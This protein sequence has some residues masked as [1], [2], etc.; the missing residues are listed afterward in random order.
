MLKISQCEIK[1]FQ[2]FL[3]V[4]IFNPC[5]HSSNYPNAKNFNEKFDSS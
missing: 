5:E 2:Q 3:L 1:F 4:E